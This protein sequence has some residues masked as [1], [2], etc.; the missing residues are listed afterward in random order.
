MCN[1]V[2]Y[3]FEY[4]GQKISYVL[5]IFIYLFFSSLYLSRL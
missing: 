1:Y 5:I 2:T 4:S 3:I